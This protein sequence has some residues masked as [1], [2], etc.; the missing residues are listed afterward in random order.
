MQLAA[1]AFTALAGAVTGGGAAAGATAAGAAAAPAAGGILGALGSGST[2]LSALQLGIG[3][4]GAVG[5]L[6]AGR[7]QADALNAQAVDAEQQATN[8]TIVGQERRSSL[9]KQAAEQ[10]AQRQAAYA[11]GGVDLS[12]GTPAQ[13]Q[14]DDVRD[15]EHALGIDQYTEEQRRNRLLSRAGE[16]RA[17]AASARNAS[18][19][20]AFTG[21]A[22]AVFGIARRG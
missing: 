3:A 15:A 21:G 6:A 19:I 1:A 14:A 7:Q 10:V 18:M 22:E 8:E 2:W 5:T 9:R 11:A 16:F 17:A 20:R 12:F 4:L 13:A